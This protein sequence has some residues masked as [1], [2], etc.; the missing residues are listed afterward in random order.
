MKKTLAPLERSGAEGFDFT[1]INKD[2][3][4]TEAMTSEITKR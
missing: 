1:S 2:M 4:A 3:S